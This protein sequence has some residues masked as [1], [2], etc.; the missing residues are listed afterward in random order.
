[1]RA[2]VTSGG[3]GGGRGPPRRRRARRRAARVCR[4]FLRAIDGGSGAGYLN[5]RLRGSMPAAAAPALAPGLLDEEAAANQTFEFGRAS[6]PLG[7]PH[8]CSG[9]TGTR[10][11]IVRVSIPGA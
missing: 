4:T 2:P 10:L 11:R 6:V 1:M 7:L 3:A 8:P 5:H 9:Q